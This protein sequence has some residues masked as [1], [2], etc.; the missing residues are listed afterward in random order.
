MNWSHI[1]WHSNVENQTPLVHS[2]VDAFTQTG[3]VSDSENL[4]QHAEWFASTPLNAELKTL[5]FKICVLTHYT[6]SSPVQDESHSCFFFPS[7]TSLVHLN[8][9]QGYKDICTVATAAGSRSV[10][11]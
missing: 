1:L 2:S 4:G 3:S 8:W 9:K 11:R 6:T 5:R 10:F 7:N